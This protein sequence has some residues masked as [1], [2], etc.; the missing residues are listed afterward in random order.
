M[1]AKAP[2][3][4]TRN[5][6]SDAQFLISHLCAH[7]YRFPEKCHN[8]IPK[9]FCISR[10]C[11]DTVLSYPSVLLAWHFALVLD[12]YS[13]WLRELELYSVSFLKKYKPTVK[14]AWHCTIVY[15]QRPCLTRSATPFTGPLKGCEKMQSFTVLH[16]QVMIESLR[17]GTPFARLLM[18]CKILQN[19]V[20][21]HRP[22]ISE[23]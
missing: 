18:R 3:N 22:I 5:G 1:Y 10:T 17:D 12:S 7:I 6:L 16:H 23:P 14:I 19:Y 13:V 2:N 15:Y 9:L 11:M 4:P 21:L 8:K 20:A